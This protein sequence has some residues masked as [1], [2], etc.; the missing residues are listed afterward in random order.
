MHLLF[1]NKGND[2]IIDGHLF[3][4]K[5]LSWK[6]I[7]TKRV[8]LCFFIEY[9]PFDPCNECVNKAI[10]SHSTHEINSL[11]KNFDFRELILRNEKM[12]RDRS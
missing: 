9:A 11:F 6:I 7:C 1:Y 3:K 4:D 5:I 12:R 8:H 10:F 2:S